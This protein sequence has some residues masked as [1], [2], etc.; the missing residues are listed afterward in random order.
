MK[1]ISLRSNKLKLNKIIKLEIKG[2]EKYGRILAD[3]LFNGT[4]MNDWMVQKGY[5][6]NYDGGKKIRDPKWDDHIEL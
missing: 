6:V 5:A 2:K 1:Y 4:N 3:V